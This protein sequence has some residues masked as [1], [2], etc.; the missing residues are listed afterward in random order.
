M[1]IDT[2]VSF[3]NYIEDCEICCNPIKI[4]YTSSNGE[5]IFFDANSV[6]Q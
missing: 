2:S 4:D 5:I 3:Q 6:E 1:L